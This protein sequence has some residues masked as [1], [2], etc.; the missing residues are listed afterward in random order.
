MTR[1]DVKTLA[2]LAPLGVLLSL[3]WVWRTNPCLDNQLGN[4]WEQWFPPPAPSIGPDAMVVENPYGILTC[5]FW[6]Q[7]YHHVITL[8][9]LVFI[10]GLVGFLAASRF[11]QYPVKRGAVVMIGS[12]TLAMIVANVA[13]LPGLLRGADQYSHEIAAIQLAV[14]LAVVVIGALIATLAAWLTLKR[15]A[16]G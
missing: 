1:P 16:R 4:Q 6:P 13:F 2:W 3:W 12:L 11:E 9:L 15:R 10:S 7:P 5:D 14:S 8:V